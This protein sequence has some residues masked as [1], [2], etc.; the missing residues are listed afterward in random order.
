[1]QSSQ[2]WVPEIQERLVALAGERLSSTQIAQ[3]LSQEFG[4]Q[5]TRSAV[6]GRLYRC[7]IPLRGNSAAPK[8]LANAPKEKPAAVKRVANTFMISV[9]NKA[10]PPAPSAP[11][12]T[13][14]E[15]AEYDA[16]GLGLPLLDVPRGCCKWPISPFEAVSHRFCAL[17]VED[18]ADIYCA[19]HRR[20]AKAIN[21]HGDP[22]E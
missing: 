11:R 20:R 18:G 5:F 3:A 17:P 21:Y 14:K 2:I 13:S 6:I 12:R 4:R 10:K 22:L 16:Q 1:M 15:A 7:K 9:P 19:A 8:R